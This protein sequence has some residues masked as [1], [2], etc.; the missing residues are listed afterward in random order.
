MRRRAVALIALLAPLA[1]ACAAVTRVQAPRDLPDAL[2]VALGPPPA[3]AALLAL[4]LA[5][6]AVEGPTPPM[7]RVLLVLGLDDDARVDLGQVALHPADRPG[8]FLL[9][10]PPATL[11]R[12]RWAPGPLYLMLEPLGPAG[13]GTTAWR[14]SAD[15]LPE[16]RPGS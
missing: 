12:A 11:Q 1:V 8:R 6:P 10:V 15:W 9:R 4:T 3:D 14:A 2:P 13:A 16:P 7:W 5:P